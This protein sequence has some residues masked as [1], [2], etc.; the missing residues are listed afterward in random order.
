[1]TAT[2][3]PALS[4]LSE[5]QLAS[6]YASV[7]YD[8]EASGIILAEMA[9]RD[10]ND[11]ARADALRVRRTDPV[12]AEWS[13]ASLAQFRQA[14][15]A[16][17]G[18]LV[19]RGIEITDPFTL[20]S[21]PEWLARKRA[22]EELNNFWDAHPRIPT[23]TEWR[24]HERGDIPPDITEGEP[25]EPTQPGTYGAPEATAPSQD[26]RARL[27]ARVAE[28]HA[29]GQQRAAQMNPSAAVA[30]RGQSAVTVTR[31]PVD[32]AETL[33]Y[34]YTFLKRFAVWNSEAEIVAAALWVAQSHARDA[35]GMP[36]WEYCARFAILGP[37]GSGK[38]RKS[39]LVGKLA[40]K[41]KILVEPT[42]PSFIDLCAEHHT[43]IITEADEA[44]R[45]PGRSRG[46]LA[47]INASYEPDRSSSRKQGGQVIDIPL[48][49]PIVLDGIDKV[50][51]S[52]NRP[53]LRAMMSRAVC[54]LSREAPA[55]YR[56]PRF[57]AQAR[58]VADLLSQRTSAWM[59]QEVEA[60]MAGDRPTVPDH[61]G[62][63]PFSL[64]E[65][66]F[67]VALRAD[68]GDP[69]G[70]WSR[71][72]WDACEQLE[73]QFGQADQNEEVKAE[74]DRTMEEWGLE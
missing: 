29:Q 60:G 51:L 47:V 69:G 73:A 34:I 67:T 64:W 66:M 15:A 45:S 58:N 6:L 16:C 54:V 42:K 7:S 28:L 30:V 53:D 52:E 5:D 20:W 19:R 37:S 44:F 48:F 61:L 33:R 41:G 2:D 14:E 36:I 1:M 55:G 3:A 70:P 40:Y 17:Q 32:G 13:D 31:E 18:N 12:V 10:R 59:A 57:D 65:P 56:A 9:R 63:R 27:D 39:R 43:V 50:L 25:M 46:I 11:K 74:L 71:A 38:S 8:A 26:R 72:C 49:V 21:G 35:G 22:T 68:Q 24:E 4:E 62:N 23:V